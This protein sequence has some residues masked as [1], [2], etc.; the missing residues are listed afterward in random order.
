MEK[1]ER[2]ISIHISERSHLNLSLNIYHCGNLD[3]DTRTEELT[4]CY[5]LYYVREGSGYLT[6]QNVTHR[7]SAGSA[8]VVF[9][10][11]K[12]TLKAEPGKI[13]NV[14]W[15]AFSGYLVDNYLERGKLSVYNPIF[16]DNPEREL[17]GLFDSFMN[18]S[19]HMPNRYCKLMSDLYLIF[20]FLLD[21]VGPKDHRAP[22]TAD[23]ILLLALDYIDSNYFANISVEDI[24][25]AVATNRK[26]LYTV[27]KTLTG[28][29]PRDYLICYRIRKST[30]LLLEPEL[31]IEAV[32]R[33]SGYQDQFHFSK[34]FKKNV[35]M[36]PTEYRK[37]VAAD[38]S[39]IYHSPIDEVIRRTETEG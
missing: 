34:E 20:A 17:G 24:A 22:N 29:S 21:N 26:T 1:I 10:R 12:F 5:T 30:N 23:Q 13:F 31:T 15:I 4:D 27:F 8:F 19:M 25:D 28:F 14:T 2:N 32:A 35:G 38:P 37:M 9:P 16:T 3:V 33:S 36:P 39:K 11:T 18:R 6:E 7:L